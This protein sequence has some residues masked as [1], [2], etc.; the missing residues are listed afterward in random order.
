MLKK[1][2]SA[3]WNIFSLGFS[4]SLS[5]CSHLPLLEQAEDKTQFFLLIFLAFVQ[6]FFQLP[7][8]TI[9][10]INGI[11]LLWGHIQK[12]CQEFLKIRIL[13]PF[14]MLETGLIWQIGCSVS[15]WFQ[16]NGEVI[17]KIMDGRQG[18]L[19][20]CFSLGGFQISQT[21]CNTV[22]LSCGR[23]D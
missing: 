8:N 17:N 3:K 12:K 14:V 22:F 18:V 23:K 5:P 6:P 2:I 4:T 7:C 9:Q 10:N 15:L 1:Y 19:H 21:E 20:V 11:F 13:L 16:H